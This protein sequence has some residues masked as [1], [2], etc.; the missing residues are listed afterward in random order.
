MEAPL[1]AL[2]ALLL[3]SLFIVS[4]FISPGLIPVRLKFLCSLIE[5]Q[6]ENPEI[7]LSILWLVFARAMES[8]TKG[9]YAKTTVNG[10][11]T[12][13]NVQLIPMQN[14]IMPYTVTPQA[15][16]QATVSIQFKIIFALVLAIRLQKRTFSVSIW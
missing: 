6:A 10:T 2:N 14:C 12:Q 9:T 16:G 7:I 11:M 3:S 5:I 8:S 13:L 15:A 4:N 1:P